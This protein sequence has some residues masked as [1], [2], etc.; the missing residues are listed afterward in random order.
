MILQLAN[1]ATLNGAVG[2]PLFMM[3]MSIFNNVGPFVASR[4]G[5]R[6]MISYQ[7]LAT[8]ICAFVLNW[9]VFSKNVTSSLVDAALIG[10]L[11]CLIGLIIRIMN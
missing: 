6:W 2:Q 1:G 7:P 10:L 3:R 11:V 5:F 8:G 9:L 4:R